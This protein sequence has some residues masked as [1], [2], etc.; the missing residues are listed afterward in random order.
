MTFTSIPFLFF[1]IIVFVTNYYLKDKSRTLFLLLT[2]YVFYGLFDLRF[3]PILWIITLITFISS[4][5]MHQ[6]AQHKKLILF[7]DVFVTIGILFFYKYFNFFASILFNNESTNFS[8][9]LPIGISFFTFQSLGY[10][11]DVYRDSKSYEPNFLNLALFIGF[12][13]QLTSGPISRARDLIPQIQNKRE[14]HSLEMES[15]LYQFLWGMFKKIV[16]A[17]NFA[18][19]AN[20]G[21]NNYETTFGLP[22]LLSVIAYSIQIYGDF[23]GYSDMAIGLS[24]M[25]GFNL[26]ENFNSPYLSISIKDF[27]SRWH[28][29]LSTWF[30]DYVY[31]PL[32]GSRVGQLRKYLNLLI[33]FMVSGLWHGANYTFIIWGALH[34]FFQII[35]DL[36]SKKFN[37]ALIPKV[38]RW[39]FTMF[40]VSFAWIFFRANSLSHALGIIKSIAVFTLPT[41]FGWLSNMLD[42]VGLYRFNA[43]VL[44]IAISLLFYVEWSNKQGTPYFYLENRIKRISLLWGVGLMLVILLFGAFSNPSFIYF[45]F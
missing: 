31:I 9:L 17:D 36:L 34:G 14:I 7:F 38:I 41:N 11:I 6:Y 3:L 45:N 2:S 42:S 21:F 10:V 40:V 22:I 18:L 26:K 37:I 24:R 33:T 13:P 15:G 39:L 25:L 29:S 1:F 4:K 12:F 16:I 23:S 35:E 5:L 8:I 44:I 19:I 27:W 32:G 20:H 43:V 28:I 30:K